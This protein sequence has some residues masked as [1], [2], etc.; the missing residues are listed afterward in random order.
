M[1]KIPGPVTLTYVVLRLGCDTDT[2]DPLV[3]RRAWLIRDLIFEQAWLEKDIPDS[4]NLIENVWGPNMSRRKQKSLYTYMVESKKTKL[5]QVSNLLRNVDVSDL[6]KPLTSDEA[7][8]WG[9]ESVLHE[10]SGGCC[11]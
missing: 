2:P 4:I 7:L 9:L 8:R 11:E 5:R 3:S 1:S 10:E 6:L